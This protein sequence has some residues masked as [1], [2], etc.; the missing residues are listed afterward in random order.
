MKRFNS[1][2]LHALI[3]IVLT[4][5]SL[6]ALPTDNKLV[7]DFT[8][9]GAEVNPK[10]Y[11][12]F[13]E[14]INHSGDGALY[15]ELIRNRNFEEHVIP[16][17]TT[18]KDG[19]VHTPHSKNYATGH[20]ADWKVEWKPDSLKMIGWKVKGTAD[21]DIVAERPLHPNTPN[22]MKLDMKEKG[23]VLENEGYWG[24]SVKGGEKYDLRFYVNAAQYS[25]NVTVK[26]VSSTGET[27]AEKPFDIT[28]QGAWQEYTAELI[29]STTDF[30]GTLQL[31]FNAPGKVYV[32]YVSLFP[33]KTFKGRKNGMRHD[34]AQLLAD[35]K[36][37]F[38][39]WPGGCIVEGMTYEN[40]A[41]WQE[42][43]GDPMM[44]RSEWILWN[45][46]CTWG[47]G[48][49][50]FLQFCEDI[51][52]DAMFV[53]NVGLS[54]SVRNGDYTEN[55]DPIIQDICDAIEY[56]TGDV[57]TTWGAKRAEAGH[58]QPFNL[59]YV[60]LGNEQS[61]DYYA[62]RHNYL[63]SILKPKYPDITFICTLQLE[64]SLGLLKEADMI[65]PH[66]YVNPDYFYD[67]TNLFD[68]MDRGKY[69]VYVGEYAVIS[70]G[71]MEGALSEAAF[72]SGMERN[73]DLVK[74]A[75]YAPL[76]ENS[77]LR[78]WPTNLIWVNNEK[79]FGRTSY[80]V[81]K[82]YGLNLPTYNLSTDLERPTPTPFNGYIGLGSDNIKD[83][84]RNLK[85]TDKAGNILIEDNDFSTF[86]KLEKP[87]G[88]RFRM[89]GAATN[90]LKN[91]SVGNAII[92]FE[93]CAIEEPVPANSRLPHNMSSLKTMTVM[94][95]LA[96][97]ADEDCMNYYTL[98]LGSVGQKSTL[99]VT[100]TIDGVAG[101]DRDQKGPTF[102]MIPGEWY[103][104]RIELEG[105]CNLVC[106]A[107]DSKIFEQKVNPLNKIHAVSGYDK[108]MG[109]TIV[110]FV[111]GTNEA[112]T[113]QV[114][115]NCA[116]AEKIGTVI[117]LASETPNGENS[118]DEPDK[119]VPVTTTYN[120]FGKEFQYT[121]APN[122][123]TILRI[124]TSEK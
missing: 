46:H 33:Q 36:P 48:Y 25:G 91:V 89:P 121:F 112:F 17:G 95:S 58:P 43:L 34:V 122:S 60:E 26:I 107:N 24:L 96:F 116:K 108:A 1:Y 98:N 15:A 69:D 71:N 18:Y 104:F 37:G 79:T 28:N 40:R 83:Q 99:S 27:L 42:T 118:Y 61:G 102:T 3:G 77:N 64:E 10:M 123:F 32:D 2:C 44:R 23:V 94:P 41:K 86:T 82:M 51:D 35:L 88:N 115:L 7:I 5:C 16:S 100:R 87:Q 90:I 4:S 78:D 117:T 110:K 113:T 19:Y 105:D 72:I 38:M 55:L 47:F 84:Y 20:Y 66:W 54:C 62:E 114:S 50:E 12:I 13:F 101:Y 6:G 29:P 63:Y 65:D 53:A 57:A 22:A 81:Q 76:I 39:R 52:A 111:N 73:G 124:K 92:E 106:Y 56:A 21:Y 120:N 49:H 74:M 70:A 80:H 30:K 67:N 119:I 109:E 31:V 68:D 93:A 45:Y 103:K 59:K 11:G 97:G 8:Q 85:V 14:E 75:S 9:P